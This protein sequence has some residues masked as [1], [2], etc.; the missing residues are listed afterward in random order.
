MW[1]L[2][3]RTIISVSSCT[4]YSALSLI[5][6]SLKCEFPLWKWSRSVMSDS[7][8]PHGLQPAR[9][10]CPWDLPHCRQML[11]SSESAWVLSRF[12]SVRL[13][14]TID[15]STP[16]SSVHGNFAG[17]NTEVGCHAL[18]QG[19][20]PSH[21]SNMHLLC[22]LYWQAGSLPLVPSRKPSLC[23]KCGTISHLFWIV[24]LDTA[25][26]FCSTLF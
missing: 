26:L 20:F 8:Q 22:L 12:N 4:R 1:C 3:L 10:L 7:L 23:L 15:C 2:Q 13:C 11:L 19:I 25:S 24:H 18:L 21:G 5:L 16:G 17:K 6:Q 14:N 9:L